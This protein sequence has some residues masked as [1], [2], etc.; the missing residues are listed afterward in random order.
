[1]TVWYKINPNRFT[2]RELWRTSGRGLWPFA[3]AVWRKWFDIQLPPTSGF[4][5]PDSL[6]F[7]D[8][9]SLP[10]RPRERLRRMIAIVERHEFRF[11][12][13]LK[14]RHLGDTEEYA[15]V[16]ISAD[17]LSLANLFW[18][19]IGAQDGF[20]LVLGSRTQTRRLLTDACP[21]GADAPPGFD[22]WNGPGKSIRTDELIAQHFRRLDRLGREQIL[23][24]TESDIAA[25]IIENQSQRRA[26]DLA[27]GVLVPMTQEEIERLSGPVM[28]EVVAEGANPF[29]APREDEAA[30]PSSI[31]PTT[32]PGTWQG[33]VMAGFFVGF[34]LMEIVGLA[35]FD[36]QDL[37]DMRKPDGAWFHL[38]TLFVAWPFLI[39]AFC[40]G[41]GLAVWIIRRVLW[42]WI[43]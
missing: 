12:F 38:F 21:R 27:R 29:R 41:I 40:A 6:E 30:S 39:G 1:M 18:W 25:R 17:G 24:A 3:R 15:A 14:D 10:E 28:A 35:S 5:L 9:D 36:P 34:V 19:K 33:S 2:Y 32:L 4:S 11:V 7:V 42:R 23:P 37:E 20:N 31:I 22:V 13:V 8:L 16:L 26:F 43:P